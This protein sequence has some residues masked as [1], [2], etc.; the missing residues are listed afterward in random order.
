MYLNF[1]RT[2]WQETKTL[3][4]VNTLAVK[5]V[6]TEMSF[7]IIKY[8]FLNFVREVF[9]FAGAGLLPLPRGNE[10]NVVLEF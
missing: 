5:S 1:S 10:S 3:E 7:G 8:S 4:M 2:W 9:K 6:H